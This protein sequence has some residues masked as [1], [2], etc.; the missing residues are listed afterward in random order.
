MQARDDRPPRADPKP[1]RGADFIIPVLAA[2]FT[3]YFLASTAELTWEAKANG[4]VIGTLL[5][6]LVLVQ[7]IR[8]GLQIRAG[9][10]SGSLGEIAAWSLPQARR[11]GLIAVLALFVATIQWIGTTLGLFLAMAASMWVM[12]VRSWK[13]L[14]G[15]SFAAA[16]S[17]YIL[18]IFLLGARMPEGVVERA[19]AA[20]AGG[21]A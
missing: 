2:G 12:G 8:L 9:E 13:V 16:A 17:V 3:I 18:F 14:L 19:L 1:A 20:L 6:V 4:V 7:V 5:L 15:V 10:V 11:L 21:S